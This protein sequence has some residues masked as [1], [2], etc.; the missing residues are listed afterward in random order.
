MI[1]GWSIV[2]KALRLIREREEHGRDMFPQG[3]DDYAAHLK[4]LR[5]VGELVDFYEKN[6]SLTASQAASP[7][8]E[9][10]PDGKMK[11]W[12]ERIYLHPFGED[13]CD[14]AWS[15]NKDGGSGVEYVLADHIPRLERQLAVTQQCDEIPPP[16]EDAIYE[17]GAVV[18]MLE[19]GK[20][21][22]EGI[23]TEA[24][25]NGP[26]VDWHYFGGRAVVKT[27]GN[28]GEARKA[29]ERALPRFLDGTTVSPSLPAVEAEPC[30]WMTQN[31]GLYSKEWRLTLE[32][33]G[34]D[35]SDDIPLYRHPAS[36]A[37]V[38]PE[39]CA[40]LR[41][42]LENVFARS[43][44]I[45]EEDWYSAEE[46][47]TASGGLIST[48][49][50]EF[51]A[52]FTPVVAYSLLNFAAP[53]DKPAALAQPQTLAEQIECLRRKWPQAHLQKNE[54][55]Q[56]LVVVPSVKL[57][58]GCNA[59]IC[60]LLFVAPAGFPGSVPEGFWVDVPNLEF[61]GEKLFWSNYVNPIPGFPA[62]RDLTWF[63]WHLQAWNPNRDTL[64]AVVHAILQSLE[65]AA[66]QPSTL[67]SDSGITD[68]GASELTVRKDGGE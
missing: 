22:M 35:L 54:H 34:R 39:N 66:S 24:S 9:A 33:D 3:A 29:L 30:A 64:L 20:F 15:E 27:L 6:F 16:C 67:L 43:D 19:G 47:W 31:G 13:T 23:T 14:A 59:T 42:V 12:P 26:K 40:H 17:R 53:A 55:G 38:V 50:A 8:A 41:Q 58:N 65:V 5:T 2:R 4:A 18:A 25:R 28:V 68:C 49:D 37:P 63:K 44:E 7:E 56:H 36:A 21:A 1:D 57:P 60:T 51:I 32:S 61:N 45:G 62:W 11:M 10:S 46:L 52:A 48:P